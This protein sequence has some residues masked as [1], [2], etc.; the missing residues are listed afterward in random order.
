MPVLHF[1]DAEAR[2]LPAPASRTDY[3]DDVVTGLCLRVTPTGHKSWAVLYRAGKRLRRLTLNGYPTLLVADAR[4][5]A[6]DALRE[7]AQGKD[8]ASAK[9]TA[10]EALTFGQ[11]AGHYIERYAKPHKRS[12]HADAR[13]LR[14]FC[15]RPWG[16]IRADALSRA[17]VR[18]LLAD[19]EAERSGVIANRLR[20]CLG[21]LFSWAVAEGFVEENPVRG[22]TRAAEGTSRARVLTDREVRQF[23]S[24]L[25]SAERR[26]IETAARS[27]PPA[28][29]ISPDVAFWLRVR[30]LTGQRGGEVADLQWAD[31]DLDRAC[32]E[33]P[34]A[35]FKNGR[36]HV[37]PLAPQTLVLLKEK[38]TRRPDDVFVCE[39]GRGR[40]ARSGVGAA[41]T[42][43]NFVPHDLRRTAATRMAQAGVTPFIIAR[44]LGHADRTVTGIYNR[45]QYLEE[46]REALVKWE[47]YLQSL[48]ADGDS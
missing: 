3:F 36:P 40:A 16:T 26:W 47:T 45:W 31:V 37:H 14:V 25:A 33:V 24:E 11:L 21:K 28:N 23:L 34:A 2:D 46:K 13:Q 19:V 43:A 22:L 42:I 29:A 32:W 18:E 5:A 15:Q 7:V 6:R 1:T 41:F 35:R 12:W 20:S 9:R 8:P 48:A 17:N 4:K 38:R 27:G 39:G 44:V 30:L 10:I